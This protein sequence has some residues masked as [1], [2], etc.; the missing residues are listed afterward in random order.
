MPMRSFLLFTLAAARTLLSQAGPPTEWIDP[1]TGHRVIRLSHEPGTAS[2]YFHQNAYAADGKKLVV[3]N[4]HGIATIN[5]ATREINQVVEGRVNILV[6]GHKTGRIYYTK[7]GAIF[8]TDLDTHATREVAKIPP[9][10]GRGG[11][12]AVNADETMLVGIAAD[13][14]GKTVPR[15]PPLNGDGGRLEANWAAGTPKMLY[16]IDLNIFFYHTISTENDWTNHLQMSP[17]DP[18]LI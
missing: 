16:A 7:N 8:A 6:T 11:A 18:H 10:A 9:Q 4:P 14:D 15:T 1:A 17:T 2:L 12:I 3:T 13:P 5:L